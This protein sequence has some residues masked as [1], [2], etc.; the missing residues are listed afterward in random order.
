MNRRHFLASSALAAAAALG[1]CGLGGPAA[2]NQDAAQRF[3]TERNGGTPVVL[4]QEAGR[5]MPVVGFVDAID[6]RTLTVRPAAGGASA[7]VQLADGAKIHKDV[8]IQLSELKAGEPIVAFGSKQGDVFR[9]D[10]VRIGDGAP[11]GGAPIV[12]QRGAGGS[13]GDTIITGGPGG[14]PGGGDQ[15]FNA[16]LPQPVAGTLEK[17]DGRTIAL[18]D[19][20]GASVAVRLADGAKI[21]RQAEIPLADLQTGAF[22]MASG[23]QDGDTFRATQLQI[24]PP[25]QP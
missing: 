20:D 14:Q 23:A 7:T 1:A 18:K 3:L 4:G 5:E 12:F 25:P 21:R 22:I 17:I 19:A 24:L 2:R 10:L 13:G 9:A 11:G 16:E 6:G 15:M 8:D